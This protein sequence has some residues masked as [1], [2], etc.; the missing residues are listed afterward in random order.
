MAQRRVALF[1]RYPWLK[2]VILVAGVVTIAL[3]FAVIEKMAKTEVERGEVGVVDSEGINREEAAAERGDSE[4]DAKEGVSGVDI[5]DGSEVD[6]EEAPE[7]V[8]KEAPEVTR[9]VE[10]IGAGQVIAMTFD[11]GPSE[12]TGRLLD[13]LKEK[14][15]PATF[16]VLGNRV[17]AYPDIIRREVAEGHEVES[18]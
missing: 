5:K 16:F 13:I 9:E 3:I 18:H 12:Y 8:A 17:N 14:Q 10:Q 11:D 1:R 6:T 4:A 15:V 7:V 2:I